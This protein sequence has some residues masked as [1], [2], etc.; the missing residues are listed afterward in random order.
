MNNTDPKKKSSEDKPQLQLIP[1][2]LNNETA[3]ALSRGAVKHGP[4]NWRENKVEMMTYLGAIKRHVDLLLNGEDIDPDTGAHHLGCVAAG[5]GIVLD[6]RE[7]GTLVDNRPPRKDTLMQQRIINA[8]ATPYT[9]HQCG[10]E[11]ERTPSEKCPT[12]RAAVVLSVQTEEKPKPVCFGN[13]NFI[14]SSTRAENGCHDCPFRYQC[15]LNKTHPLSIKPA[16]RYDNTI[17]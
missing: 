4:W 16:D 8:W 10:S 3:K 7:H 15:L 11:W 12:C 13:I 17:G 9:C 5:C 14:S 1:P 6:A 2:V